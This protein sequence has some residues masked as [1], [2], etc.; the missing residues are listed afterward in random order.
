MW[1]PSFRTPLL[2]CNIPLLH[3]HSFPDKMTRLLKM[4]QTKHLSISD[5]NHHRTEVTPSG[6]AVILT[7]S[8]KVQIS[9]VCVCV[10]GGV[11]V[12]VGVPVEDSPV[13]RGRKI[14]LNIVENNKM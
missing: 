3:T 10:C 8:L 4:M 6:D 1:Y 9:A 13:R 5:L 12:G 14:I 2:Q 11:G 7:C